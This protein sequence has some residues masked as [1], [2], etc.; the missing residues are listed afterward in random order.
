MI[1]DRNESKPDT[2][3]DTGWDSGWEEHRRAQRQRLARLPL[4][5]KLRWLEEA[6]VVVEN[7]ERS[8]KE[9]G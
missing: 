2:G 9:R 4:I 8:R 3:R 6:Q 1:E 7:L 5:E